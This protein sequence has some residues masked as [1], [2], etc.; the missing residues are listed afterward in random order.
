MTK[1]VF[2]E[3]I[4]HN[5]ESL[6]RVARA[7][8]QN[9]EECQDAISEAITKGFEKL[10]TLKKDEYVKTW[11]IRILINECYAICRQNKWKY[12][13]EAE[14]VAEADDY[15]ELYAAINEL[16]EKQRLAIVLHHLEGYS[17]NEIAKMMKTSAGAVKMNLSRGRKALREYLEG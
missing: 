6:Y 13:G 1:E 16:N 2:G 11:L 8:L 7:I 9:D 5:K 15:R 12:E 17:I 14:I 4:L 10:H 3:M